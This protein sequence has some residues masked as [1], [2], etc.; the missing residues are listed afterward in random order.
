MNNHRQTDILLYSY[1]EHAAIKKHKFSSRFLCMQPNEH[2]WSERH[3][4]L[5]QLKMQM[6]NNNMISV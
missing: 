6:Q 3:L 1:K 2:N 5:S 4:W